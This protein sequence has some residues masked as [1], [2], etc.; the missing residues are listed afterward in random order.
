MIDIS[1]IKFT[2]KSGEKYAIEIGLKRGKW[3][4]LQKI[5]RHQDVGKMSEEIL[6][7]LWFTQLRGLRTASVSSPGPQ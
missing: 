7:L 1:K 4:S 2:Y 3:S 5:V 6:N